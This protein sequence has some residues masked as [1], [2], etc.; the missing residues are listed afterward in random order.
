[1]NNNS[2]TISVPAKIILFGEHAVVYGQPAVAIP[3]MDLRCYGTI[4]CKSAEEPATISATD[5]NVSY[6]P[7]YEMPQSSIQ[8]IQKAIDYFAEKMQ[9]SLPLNGWAMTIRSDIPVGRGMGSSAA[10]SVLLIRLLAQ[11]TDIR[12]TDEDVTRYSFELEKYHHG[13]PSG[14]DNTVVS[15]AKPVFFQK[16]Q[17]IKTLK[18]ARFHF[19]IGD[20]GIGKHT[21]TIV[22]DV[23]TRCE[24][25][26]AQ[27]SRLFSRI[28][29]I[30]TAGRKALEDGDLQML[31]TLINENQSVLGEI[32]VSCT[33]LDDLIKAAMDAGA[34]GAKLCG[35]GKGGCMIALADN[36]ESARRI[37]DAVLQAGAA[38]S[39]ITILKPEE[40]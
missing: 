18:P 21:G 1:M 30:S 16:G 34:Q 22:A 37:Q 35:A 17:E 27:Y 26:P 19:V 38:K 11:M 28:G 32:G 40:Q 29:E 31:A 9:I 36:N 39:F 33:Q 12:L 4:E 6:S 15:L 25:N 8:H 13:T 10:I 7:G 3:V 23:A 20:T 14:I 24:N 5:L 2:F